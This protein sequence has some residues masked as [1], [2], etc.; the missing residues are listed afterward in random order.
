MYLVEKI[1]K[2]NGIKTDSINT[3]NGVIIMADNQN[4]TF[5]QFKV[6]VDLKEVYNYLGY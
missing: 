5:K 2:A 1:L 4:G 3:P 6:N